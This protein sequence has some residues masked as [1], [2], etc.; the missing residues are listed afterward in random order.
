ML[1]DFEG[2]GIM[3]NASLVKVRD[4]ANEIMQQIIVDEKVYKLATEYIKDSPTTDIAAQKLI[5]D[6]SDRNVFLAIIE[7]AAS[8]GKIPDLISANVGF[9]GL[10]SGQLYMVC[11]VATIAGYDIKSNPVQTRCMECIAIN[12]VARVCRLALN[13]PE[14]ILVN[15]LGIPKA[16]K[17]IDSVLE[18]GI[19]WSVIKLVGRRSYSYFVKDRDKE[20]CQ[21]LVIG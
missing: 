13:I 18:L 19:D 1:T 20:K 4:F 6:C 11:A 15:R 12:S 3:A 5:K 7:Q 16:K 8:I 17:V 21:P 10:L 2:E 14:E 9:Y